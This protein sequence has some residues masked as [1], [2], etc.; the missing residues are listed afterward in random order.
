MTTPFTKRSIV[1]IRK[2]EDSIDIEYLR[3]LQAIGTPQ[4]LKD[5]L[6]DYSD[7]LP[8]ELQKFQDCSWDEYRELNFQIRRFL[9]KVMTRQPVPMEPTEAVMF[10]SPPLLTLPRQYAIQWNKDHPNNQITWG[11]AWL[12]FANKNW[13]SKIIQQASMQLK[14]IIKVKNDNKD[15]IN[16]YID[17]HNVENDRNVRHEQQFAQAVKVAEQESK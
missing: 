11:E 15:M 3:R 4:Q 10:L 1:D 7:F 2:Q 14:Q 12:R 16:E 13:I 17:T 9:H 6:K 5:I 8:E